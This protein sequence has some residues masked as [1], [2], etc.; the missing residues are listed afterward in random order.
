MNLNKIARFF[1]G[2]FLINTDSLDKR[3]PFQLKTAYARG[4]SGRQYSDDPSKHRVPI[5][6]KI[7]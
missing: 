7:I 2:R 4:N 1:C 5:V 6:T 3:A